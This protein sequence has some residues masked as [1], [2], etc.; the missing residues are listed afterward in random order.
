MVRVYN[1]SR[2]YCRLFHHFSPNYSNESTFLICLS[3][4][5]DAN[6]SMKS[7]KRLFDWNSNGNHHYKNNKI[8]Y[9]IS[10]NIV[11]DEQRSYLSIQK[12][13]DNCILYFNQLILTC[14][15]L[16]FVRSRTSSILV[17]YSL[18]L[19][20]L[21]LWNPSKASDIFAG[22]RR[23]HIAIWSWIQKVNLN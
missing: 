3:T 11:D 6:S 22:E 9:K 20:F 21:C 13:K 19:Y 16:I 5:S 14:M 1:N 12:K 15:L 17:M 10:D 18:Y 4:F 23:S 2:M 8:I 7:S